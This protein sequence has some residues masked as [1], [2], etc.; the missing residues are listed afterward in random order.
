MSA[1]CCFLLALAISITNINSASNDNNIFQHEKKEFSQ[2]SVGSSD[3]AAESLYETHDERADM[4]FGQ[5]SYIIQDTDICDAVSLPFQYP[6]CRNDFE[7]MKY[8]NQSVI[9][10][11]MFMEVYEGKE[12]DADCN[13]ERNST[14]N[15]SILLNDH[16][17]FLINETIQTN[18]MLYMND[19]INMKY[20][21]LNDTINNVNDTVRNMLHMWN[22]KLDKVNTTHYKQIQEIVFALKTQYA[23]LNYTR[24]GRENQNLE[25]KKQLNQISVTC[26][27]QYSFLTDKLQKQEMAYNKQIKDLNESWKTKQIKIMQQKDIEHSKLI[28]EINNNWQMKYELLNAKVE[29]QDAAHNHA[30]ETL[31]NTIQTYMISYMQKISNINNTWHNKHASIK[32][33]IEQ[34]K[35]ERDSCHGTL[36]VLSSNINSLNNQLQTKDISCIQAIKDIDDTS[37][38]EYA[39]LNQSYNEMMA[40]NSNLTIINEKLVHQVDLLNKR[41]QLLQDGTSYKSFTENITLLTQTIETNKISHS[42]LISHINESWQTKL[43]D[44]KIKLSKEEKKVTQK[45]NQWYTMNEQLS[46]QKESLETCLVQLDVLMDQKEKCEHRTNSWFDW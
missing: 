2:I 40:K 43:G 16:V 32:L 12:F 18:V 3:N 17:L 31:N 11:K 28:Q 13:N 36:N 15:D 21:L 24:D 7:K 19:T 38:S 22:Q 23:S 35:R 41:I 30:M 33:H 1:F 20:L 8:V 37:R 9:N 25:H 14:S 26:Q 10:G 6:V 5:H 27:K 29:K 45:Q 42:E 44:C 39:L 34:T 46:M 4:N